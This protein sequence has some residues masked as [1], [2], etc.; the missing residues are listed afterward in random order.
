MEDLSGSSGDVRK[1]ASIG[2][3]VVRVAN[4]WK[5]R[6]IDSRGRVRKADNRVA[7]RLNFRSAGWPSELAE[8]CWWDGNVCDCYRLLHLCVFHL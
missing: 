3:D 8:C 7:P 4:S 1:D 2:R 6:A 5:K